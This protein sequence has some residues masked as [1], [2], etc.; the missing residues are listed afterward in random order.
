MAQVYRRQTTLWIFIL[1][2]LAEVYPL[3]LVIFFELVFGEI[4]F[5][6]G[7]DKFNYPVLI[8]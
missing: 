2:F 7:A 5:G 4:F 8:W 3:F 1:V 6:N